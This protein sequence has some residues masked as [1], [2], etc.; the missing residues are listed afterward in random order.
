MLLELKDVAFSYETSFLRKPS[1]YIFEGLSFE[2]EKGDSVA[3]LGSNGMGKSSLLKLIAGIYKPDHG[4]IKNNAKRT[5]LLSLQAGF[6][7]N[8]SGLDNIKLSAL[9]LGATSKEISESLNDI[10]EYSELGDKVFQPVKTYS[11]GMVLRLAFSIAIHIHADLILI[12]EVLS[13]GDINFQR[14]SYNSIKDKMHSDTT[15]ILVSHDIEAV[16][17]LCNK[18]V[19]LDEESISY[20]GDVTKVVDK[21]IAV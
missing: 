16:K 5:L 20:I 19:M 6:D 15:V 9:I 18:A 7:Y 8:L 14:K 12:D 2:I 17:E 10:I 4:I 1:S 13:V 3:I 21:Y 11:S